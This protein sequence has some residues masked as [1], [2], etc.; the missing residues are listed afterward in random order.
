MAWT[1][2]LSWTARRLAI[3]LFLVFHVG[4]TAVW[5]L[6]ICPI[7]DRLVPYLKYY[8]LPTGMWQAWAMFA[9]DPIHDTVQLEA[10]VIDCNGLRYGFA[11]PR[12]A[13]YTWWQGIPRFRYS[14]YAANLSFGEMEPTRKFAA[15]HVLRQLKLPAEVYPVSVHLLYQ[16][17]PTPPPGAMAE[18]DPMEPTR[19]HVVGTA[20]IE[21][22]REVNP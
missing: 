2:K 8:M 12:M 15:H 5:I 1:G 22:P 10:E 4:A 11:F 14:K 21:T 17:R 7:R 9:P 3:S 20:R 13:D 6:P 18:V 16:V 19:R